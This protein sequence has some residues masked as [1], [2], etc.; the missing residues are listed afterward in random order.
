MAWSISPPWAPGG[1]GCSHVLQLLKLQEQR[2]PHHD[3]CS[4]GQG[5]AGGTPRVP[6]CRTPHPHAG[7]RCQCSLTGTSSFPLLATK[8]LHKHDS[9]SIALKTLEIINFLACLQSFPGLRKLPGWPQ[10]AEDGQGVMTLIIAWPKTS[11]KGGKNDENRRM[12]V[13]E[14]TVVLCMF[15][16]GK[17]ERTD[18]SS[19]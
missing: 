3:L 7:C 13:E 18:F 1:A 17:E 6:G 8:F 2:P 14:E 9:I 16:R 12:E 15:V 10:M 19:R 5:A 4:K 11:Q